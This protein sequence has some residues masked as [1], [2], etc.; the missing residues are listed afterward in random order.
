MLVSYSGKDKLTLI[1]KYLSY[2]ILFNYFK[3]DLHHLTLKT[4]VSSNLL[5]KHVYVL[6][7]CTI[8]TLTKYF[9]K[10]LMKHFYVRIFD[11]AVF[12]LNHRIKLLVSWGLMEKYLELL[13][14]HAH[15]KTCWISIVHNFNW[16]RFQICTFKSCWISNLHNQN[17][18]WFKMCIIKVMVDSQFCI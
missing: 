12:F 18:T 11:L 17:L 7:V 9:K 4:R 8:R 1:K 5:V 2:V 14:D 15:L 10:T 13:L 6:K 16:A 3:L